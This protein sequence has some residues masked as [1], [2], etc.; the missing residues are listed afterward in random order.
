M[1]T[2]QAWLLQYSAANPKSC[3]A[4]RVVAP[5]FDSV[6][7]AILLWHPRESALPMERIIAMSHERKWTDRWTA[8]TRI[9]A[10]LLARIAKLFGSQQ[11]EVSVSEGGFFG[12]V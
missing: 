12:K 6:G 2:R 8:R 10:E 11:T 5:N 7:N 4:E 1:A 9:T 3:Y